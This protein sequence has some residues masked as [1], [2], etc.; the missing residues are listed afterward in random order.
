MMERALMTPDELKACPRAVYRDEDRFL[1]HEGQTEAVLQMGH[2][3]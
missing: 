2:P 1:S 3:V